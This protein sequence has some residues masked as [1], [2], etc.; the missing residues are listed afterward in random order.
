[1]K[2]LLLLLI[3]A[4]TT[5]ARLLG[6]GGIKSVLAENLLIKQQLLIINR[7]RHRAPVL[8]PMDR[9]CLGWL[10]L[11]ITPRRLLRAAVVIKPSTLLRFHQTLI[12]RKYSMLFS[13]RHRAKP[14]PQGPSAELIRAI[15][16]I[17]QRNPRYG[18]PRIA[19]IISNTF[20]VPIDKDVVRRV[21][22][23][24]YRP[25]STLGGG[26]SWLS[27]IGH[28]KDSLWSVDLFRCESIR[29][30]T[31]WVLVV[32]DQFTRRIIGFAVQAGD[33]DGLI[34]CRMFNQA[35][36]QAGTPRYLSS[37]ND[38]L[39][40]FH[41]WRANLR[42]LG[43]EEV[44]TVPYVPISHPFVERLIG[45]IRREYLD[46]V[47]FWNGSDLERKLDKFKDYYNGHRVHASID[48]KTPGQVS[49]DLLPTRA[50]LDRFA[51]MS[52]CRGLFHTPI[53]A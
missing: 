23:Q 33:V 37:D 19:L 30:K 26:P 34:L 32:M 46:H 18:C 14:G 15:V 43:A 38:P 36:S 10:A 49:D 20:G 16:A 22:V 9:F 11:F 1:M 17:K 8:S 12:K 50:P 40:T 29:L 5:L 39:F 13:S 3:H 35:I 53:A 31:H 52:H 42:I 6:P 2:L 44:K 47:L 21:L 41:R 24:H 25:D 28:M 7:S 27:F 48:G 45:T 51:W 4:F